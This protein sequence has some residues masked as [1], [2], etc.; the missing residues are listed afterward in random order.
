MGEALS[1]GQAK[2]WGYGE[3]EFWP[4][5]PYPNIIWRLAS[6]FLKISPNFAISAAP[7]PSI[8]ILPEGYF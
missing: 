4:D 6:R 2:R 1:S 8:C 5:A 3:N 7:F